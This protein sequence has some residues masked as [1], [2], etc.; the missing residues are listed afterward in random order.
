M[1]AETDA[2]STEVLRFCSP[3]MMMKASVEDERSRKSSSHQPSSKL[4]SQTF[5][6]I[7]RDAGI[8]H[9]AARTTR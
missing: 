8:S 4:K 7:N 5:S 3:S 9:E 6:N 1:Q 2:G